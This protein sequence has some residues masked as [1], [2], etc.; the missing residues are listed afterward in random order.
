MRLIFTASILLLIL[1]C[2]GGSSD[3]NSNEFEGVEEQPV[4]V[5][6]NDTPDDSDT[7]GE[8]SVKISSE[9]SSSEVAEREYEIVDLGDLGG[10]LTRA[11]S[12]NNLNQIVGWSKNAEGTDRAFIYDYGEMNDLFPDSNVYQD[13]NRALLINDNGVIVGRGNGMWIY[14]SGIKQRLTPGY[15]QQ[16]ATPYGMNNQ[17]IVV[18]QNDF[19]WMDDLGFI[20]YQDET[21]MEDFTNFDPDYRCRSSAFAINN[22]NQIVGVGGTAG[23][24]R[25]KQ[26]FIYE[27]GV[28]EF[29]GS[30]GGPYSY[31][32]DINENSCVVGSSHTQRYE[33]QTAFLYSDGVMV[34]I[35]TLG[36]DSSSPTAINNLNVVVGYS[37]NSAGVTRAFIY[38]NEQ[39]TDLFDLVTN[40]DGWDFIWQAVDI[41]DNGMIIAIAYRDG[42][43]RAV[44]LREVE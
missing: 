15:T 44:L 30:F 8:E 41:N 43:E 33:N 10:D 24:L 40:K 16:N 27:Q 20:S 18:G 11:E 37:E 4:V 3:S 42:Q 5:G 23:Y 14:E 38:Q 7:T 19:P 36:G 31:A 13:D 2:D 28:V 34:A 6:G 35:G 12:I 1:G 25:C 26:A 22:K 39:I 17:N 9:C 21:H 32:F 29:I